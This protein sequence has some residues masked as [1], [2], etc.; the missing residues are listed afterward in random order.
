MI[1][2]TFPL[3][4]QGMG[5]PKI[6]NNHGRASVSTPND[7]HPFVSDGFA[8]VLPLSYRVLNLIP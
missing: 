1:D 3:E 2:Y 6:L 4:M 8:R 7:L 5:T